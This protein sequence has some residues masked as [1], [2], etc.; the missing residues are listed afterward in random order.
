M[1]FDM[2]IKPIV[3]IICEIWGYNINKELENLYSSFMKIIILGV[4][5]RLPVIV[6]SFTQKQGDIL[7]IYI[8][9][10]IRIVKYWLKIS[11]ASEHRYI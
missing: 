8:C 3:I 1:C 2:L 4:K 9:I 10:Y 6:V 11:T 7:Y 5:N